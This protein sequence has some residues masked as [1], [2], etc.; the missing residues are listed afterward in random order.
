VADDVPVVVPP[1]PAP[2]WER[3]RL[4]VAYD[5]TPF[6]GFAENE[7][8]RT[9][10]GD[11]R[12]ALESV[13]GVQVDLAVA[14][15][16]DA[17]VHARGQVV[18]FDAPSLAVQPARLRRSLN[19]MLAPY[20]AVR[21]VAA[22]EPG[23]HARFS[24]RWRSYRYTVLSAEVP[25]PLLTRTAWW[26]AAPLDRHRMQDAAGALVGQ[27]D[28]SSFCRRPKGPG[29]EAVSLVRR[30]DAARWSQRSHADGHLLTFEI[31]ATAFCHQMVRSIVG[32][33][34]EVG[35]GRRG[36]GQVEAALGTGDRALAG[37]LA[38]PHGL[39]LWEVGY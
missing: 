5:G 31:R 18:S 16:T 11:L 1:P 10:A 22:A 15:R 36:V 8:V 14:G 13:L 7:G 35:R 3:I 30:V 12:A 20:V 24:A 6:R 29:G 25:D 33:L 26:V 17:G 21:E 34:V 23:F 2:G 37:Q 38:P 9:V 39:V 19:S 28:F 27:H 32:T 4:L